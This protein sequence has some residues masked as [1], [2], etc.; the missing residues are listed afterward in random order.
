MTVPG[1]RSGWDDLASA[2]RADCERCLGLCCVVLSF[3]A[4]ADFPFDKPAG[5]PC[6]HLRQDH[7][8]AVHSRLRG[9]GFLGCA[10][11]DCFGAGQKVSQVTLAG[12]DRSAPGVTELMT[13][14]FPIVRQLHELLRYLVEALELAEGLEPADRL[15][16]ERL[17]HAIERVDR[18][19]VGDVEALLALDV[20]AVLDE[21]NVLLRRVSESARRDVPLRAGQPRGTDLVGADLRGADLVGADLR[22]ADLRGASLR[23]SRLVGADLTT[24][25]LRRADLTGADLRGADLRGADLTGCLFLTQ[26]QLDAARGDR[27]TALSPPLARPAHW[28]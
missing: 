1:S 22:G 14:V 9:L 20:G 7:R 12:R 25:D 8:C 23:G 10:V 5:T 24:A 18:L 16:A 17:R 13:R 11:Y 26:A 21:A 28:G 19:T 27:R 6:T 15:L 2:L 4:S 3:S